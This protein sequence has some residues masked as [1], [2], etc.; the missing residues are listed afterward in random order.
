M[1]AAGAPGEAE[2]WAGQADAV[3]AT[4]AT[5]ETEVGQATDRPRQSAPKSHH[6]PPLSPRGPLTSADV[7]MLENSESGND[8]SSDEGGELICIVCKRHKKKEHATSWTRGESTY[9]RCKGCINAKKSNHQ[10][11][12]R[13]RE[14]LP[15]SL[16]SHGLQKKFLHREESPRDGRALGG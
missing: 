14:I 13:R 12:E 6:A 11:C 1:A 4:G 5:A 3:A 8:A 10:I 7:E 2:V 9:A 15:G 16:G